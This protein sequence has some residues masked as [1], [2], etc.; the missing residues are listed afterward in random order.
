MFPA[1]TPVTI[2]GEDASIDA[3]LPLAVVQVPP[4]VT[5]AKVVLLPW[6]MLC[7]GLV[8]AVG[9]ETIVSV[10]VAVHDPKV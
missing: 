5:L 2:T 9:V 7:V 4:G 3:M 1:F 10:F 6:Q 8:I